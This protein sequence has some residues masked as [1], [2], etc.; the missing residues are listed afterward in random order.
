MKH[1]QKITFSYDITKVPFYYYFYQRPYFIHL[2]YASTLLC[3]SMFHSDDHC[4]QHKHRHLDYFLPY[5]WF[6]MILYWSSMLR[7]QYLYDAFFRV[8]ANWLHTYDFVLP[9]YVLI[10][11]VSALLYWFTMYHRLGYMP[12]DIII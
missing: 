6:Q 1:T 5:I 4:L 11:F 8:Y 12:M 10:H 7:F 2:C 9:T 3:F